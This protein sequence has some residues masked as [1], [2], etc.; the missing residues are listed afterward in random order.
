MPINARLQESNLIFFLEASL[1]QEADAAP[2]GAQRADITLRLRRDGALFEHVAWLDLGVR[3]GYFDRNSSNQVLRETLAGLLLKR[4]R[5]FD[6][7]GE[8]FYR[9]PA[10]VHSFRST[11]SLLPEV[12]PKFVE[13]DTLLP[14]FRS[15]HLI[16]TSWAQD[17]LSQTFSAALNFASDATWDRVVRNARIFPDQVLLA[18]N[19]QDGPIPDIASETVFAGFLRTLE[20]MTVSRQLSTSLGDRDINGV[21]LPEFKRAIHNIQFWRVNLRDRIGR[22]REIT[23]SVSRSITEDIKMQSI[24]ADSAFFADEVQAL[25]EYWLEDDKEIPLTQGAGA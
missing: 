25:M 5:D 22:F 16:A 19:L 4:E 2:R 11:Q 13:P 6:A 21:D 12:S 9:V 17:G 3:L 7:I 10:L 23:E 14:A 24:R 1:R 8:F 20:H 18:L 15:A